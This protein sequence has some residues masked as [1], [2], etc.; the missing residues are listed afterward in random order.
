MLG[1]PISVARC[2]GRA[3]IVD[4]LNILWADFMFWNAG[5]EAVIVK[6]MG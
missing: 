1:R 6:G 5:V 3:A 4:D 2:R